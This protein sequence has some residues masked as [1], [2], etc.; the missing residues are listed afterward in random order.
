MTY[1]AMI[2]AQLYWRQES[3]GRNT[4][5]LFVVCGVLLAAGLFYVL[6]NG[7]GDWPGLFVGPQSPH[8]TRSAF[9]RAAIAAGLSEEDIR[10]LESHARSQGVADP[11]NLF[12]NPA[13]LDTFFKEVY[14]SIEKGSESE[15][16]A[17]E[18]RSRLFAARERLSQSA[19]AGARVSSTRQLGRGMPLSFIA[20]GEESYPSIIVAVEPEGIAIEPVRDAFGDPIRFRKGTKLTIYFY[21]QSHQGYQFTSRITG[22]ERIGTK[23]VMI[24]THSDAV[25][26]LPARY[27][28][29]R[30]MRAPCTFY[31]VVVT[32]A[33][34][35]GK[36]QKDAK[37]Q[38][39][40]FPGTIIDIS[41][42]GLGI[43]SANA[44]PAGEFIKVEFNPG[45]QTHSAFAKVLRMSKPQNIGGIMH[46]QFVRIS[47]R[48][49]NAI[50]S[51]V[52]G[53][54]E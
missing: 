29:R 9:R 17:E 38:G 34:V 22:W 53:Y 20:P 36:A 12:N 43:Q 6:K 32:E 3:S 27:H 42:G 25:A 46:V 41:A 2:L 33:K 45:G 40:P 35:K 10:F 5:I 14:R 23:E 16:H 39:I 15:R 19:A 54:G 1:D 47:Q 7:V 26:A 31:R 51:F 44:L 11:G 28:A 13:R 30:E 21:S 37:V 52:Y 24:L 49:L 48:S 18:L 4:T 50:L 8:F